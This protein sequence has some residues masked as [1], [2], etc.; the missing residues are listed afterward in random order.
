[1]DKADVPIGDR[2]EAE[3]SALRATRR[4]T[5]LRCRLI[6]QGCSQDEYAHRGNPRS[7]SHHSF[8]PRYLVRSCL[9]HFMPLLTL[10]K[11]ALKM[12]VK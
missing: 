11:T 9:R 1:M 6:A 3:Q 7:R 4:R 8:L 12:A 10:E 2:S 5:A